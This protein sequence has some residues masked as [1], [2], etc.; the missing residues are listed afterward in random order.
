MKIVFFGS[1]QF[2]VPCLKALIANGCKIS[3]CITQPDRPRARGLHL[4]GTAVKQIAQASK[5]RIYQPPRINTPE[6]IKF[7]KELNPDLFVVVSYGQILS[8]AILS[9]P[10]LFAINT[11]AS[12]LPKYRG[13]APINWAIIN[14]EQ[15]TGVTIIKMAEKMDAGPIIMQ[16]QIHIKDEDTSITLAEKLSQL[17][18]ELL[19]GTLR[20]IKNNDYKLI[21][22]AG[23]VT[24][25]PKLKKEDGLIDWRKSAQ[26]IHNL[27][28]GCLSWPG[29][30]TH[31]KGKL[32][33]IYKA[34]ISLEQQA[35]SV[36]PGE[37]LNVSKDGI[38]VATGDRNLIIEEIQI[39][40]KRRMKTEEF[41]AGHKINV[42]DKLG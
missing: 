14:N 12:I 20:Q 32:L 1:S 24:F 19:T 34:K 8:K 22:Q 41:I 26:N 33:K 3:C 15:S 42:G 29:A 2:A 39:E 40:G 17:A 4:E 36:S 30:Y 25:A 10:K 5:L 27:I 21:P 38:T 16:K 6:A 23:I 18:A 13:A 28:R 37:I 7:I 11:H 9:L 31:Y 35:N